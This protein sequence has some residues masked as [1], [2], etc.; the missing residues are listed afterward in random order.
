MQK[1]IQH[2]RNIEMRK[3]GIDM[4]ER[5]ETNEKKN[6]TNFPNYPPTQLLTSITLTKFDMK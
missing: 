6:S 5:V 1:S 4:S 3:K 2:E